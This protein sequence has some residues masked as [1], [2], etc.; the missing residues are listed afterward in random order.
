[1]ALRWAAAAG[2]A[3]LT[4]PRSRCFGA[5]PARTAFTTTGARGL[6]L[7]LTAPSSPCSKTPRPLVLRCSPDSP[8]PP[9]PQQHVLVRKEGKD[10]AWEALKAMVADMFMPLLRNVSDMR[11]LRTVYDLEDYQVGMLFGAFLGCVGWYQ[12]WKAAPSVFVDAALAYGF[13]KLSVVSSELRR[14]GKCNDL[15]ARL[16]FG[17][18]AIM[19]TRDFTKSYELMDFVKLPVFFLY[20]STFIFDVGRMKKDAKH[21]VIWTVNLLR[22]KGGFQELFRIMFYRDYISGY[23]D[24]FR[25]K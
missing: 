16:K 9:P 2:G 20:L 19:A 17:I 18:V 1:M 5:R 3:Y 11:S 10:E 25:R 15:L 23:E 22:T 7:L 4:P 6:R 21:Y 12:L 24:C 14:Q 13:Y 8:P